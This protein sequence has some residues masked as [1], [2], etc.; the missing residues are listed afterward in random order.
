MWKKTKAYTFKIYVDAGKYIFEKQRVATTR[1]TSRTF[2]GTEFQCI[3]MDDLYITKDL[4]TGQEVYS[5]KQET[6]YAP[7]IGVIAYKRWLPNGNIYDFSLE[8]ILDAE[9]FEVME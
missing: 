3:I 1:K 6:V 4:D 8:E 2:N 7:G 9:G 5:Y